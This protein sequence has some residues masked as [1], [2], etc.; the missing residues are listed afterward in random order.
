MS[1]HL[2]E[3]CGVPQAADMATICTGC[4]MR[5]VHLLRA[6]PDLMRELNITILKRSRTAAPS[7]PGGPADLDPV[8]MPFNIGAAR[9]RDQLLDVLQCWAKLV[10]EERTTPAF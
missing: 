7:G 3:A 2:C 8:M 10:S 6:V 4:Q 1:A 9:A 5:M